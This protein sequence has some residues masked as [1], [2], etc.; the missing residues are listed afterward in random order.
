[1][2][3]SC[4]VNV[5]LLFIPI[6]LLTM[7]CL[8]YNQVQQ[9]AIRYANAYDGEDDPIIIKDSNLKINLVSE[10]LESPTGM[11]FLGPDD[12]LV[13]EKNKGA[14]Q[15]IVK[16]EKL[17]EPLLDINVAN[18]GERGLLG[19]AVA[20][21][22]TRDLTYVFLYLTESSDNNDGSDR[23]IVNFCTSGQ[24]VGHRLY[25]YELKDNRLINPQ[26][27]L[28]LPPNP[29]ADHLGGVILI[30]PDNNL[31]LVTGDGDSCEYDSCKEGI[32]HSVINAQSSNVQ[33]GEL[34]EGRGGIIRITQDGKVVNSKGIIGDER[35]LNK[36]YAYGIR[37]SFGI[38]F[39]PVTDKLWDTENGPGFGDEINLVEPGF[40]SGWIRAQ[41]MWPLTDYT[42]LDP[43][44]GERGYLDN[45]EISEE[46]EN[47][48]NFN[49]KGKYSNPE[50]SW[51]L[52]VG[53][54]SI[55]FFNSDKLGIQY[56]NDIFVG[57][58]NNGNLYNFDLNKDRRQLDLR[59]VLSDKLANNMEELDEIIFANGFGGITDIEVGPDG[60]LYVLSYG[61]GT[62]YKIVEDEL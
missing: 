51:D 23:C 37:N 50:F 18:K 44:P 29:G 42:L 53:V 13:L 43:N 34:P 16:G 25:K 26:L 14:V 52:P 19:I 10:G 62:I 6:L 27:L 4:K 15:R 54:T 41:G 58:I 20:K 33:K 39:D 60:Y 2:L 1:M 61:D 36:Y 48:I 46:P 7:L 35:S 45:I 5:Y 32:D 57:D 21:N 22:N 49:N 47:L 38:D 11:A 24:P 12:I 56:K 59:G 31:Y 17:P 55:K 3:F 9:E 8:T 30:G 40:N 28:D